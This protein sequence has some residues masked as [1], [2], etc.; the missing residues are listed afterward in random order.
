MTKRAPQSIAFRLDEEYREKLEKMAKE[1]AMSPGQ[2]ARFLVIAALDNTE[3]IAI[4]RDLQ[5]LKSDM[6]SLRR[7]LSN[8]ALALLVGA[9][10]MDKREANQWVKEHLRR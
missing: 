8:V 10:R 3:R 6:S 7:D 9:G 1:S 4:R 2:F 5:N